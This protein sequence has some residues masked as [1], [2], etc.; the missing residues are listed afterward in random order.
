M[1]ISA[2]LCTRLWLAVSFTSQVAERSG[3]DWLLSSTA[4]S[5]RPA[6]VGLVVLVVVVVLVVGWCVSVSGSVSKT[7]HAE[8]ISYKCSHEYVKLLQW[9][10]LVKKEEPWQPPETRPQFQ[11]PKKLFKKSR[12]SILRIQSHRHQRRL[13]FQPCSCQK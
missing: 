13:Q 12:A 11:S 9:R 4:T 7:Q 6:V 8:R 3:P 10:V 2:S 5:R 1:L